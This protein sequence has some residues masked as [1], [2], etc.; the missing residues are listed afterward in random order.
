M[1]PYEFA[2]L[3]MVLPMVVGLVWIARRF[4]TDGAPSPEFEAWCQ[5]AQPVVVA[6]QC[7]PGG[8][9]AVATVMSAALGPRREIEHHRGRYPWTRYLFEVEIEIEPLRDVVLVRLARCAMRR[10]AQR[11]PELGA[12]VD[13]VTL[14]LGGH[15]EALWI[16][17]ELR[18]EDDADGP[19]RRDRGWLTAIAH[20]VAGTFAPTLGL[21]PWARLPRPA[22]A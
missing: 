6:M 1:G 13:R 19:D 21:P 4:E 20:G 16:H 7:A 10:G 22:N 15:L 12:T 3:W 17:A 9:S 14:G 5:N 18:A 2:A 8:A 11:R